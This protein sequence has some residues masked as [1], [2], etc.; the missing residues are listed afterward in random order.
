MQ[1]F[2]TNF[3]IFLRTIIYK[4]P[5]KKQRTGLWRGAVRTAQGHRCFAQPNSQ[6]VIEVLSESTQ[7]YKIQ[8]FFELMSLHFN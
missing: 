3:L 5:Q 2:F 4:I 8:Y 1:Y 6:V 7:G